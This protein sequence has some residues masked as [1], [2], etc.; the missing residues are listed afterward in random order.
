M[1]ISDLIFLPSSVWVLPVHYSHLVVIRYVSCS[2]V[3]QDDYCS[4]SKLF[5]SHIIH[6]HIFIHWTSYIIHLHTDYCCDYIALQCD[7][8]LYFFTISLFLLLTCS[9]SKHFGAGQS[10]SDRQTHTIIEKWRR[11]E[12]I[13]RKVG[14]RKTRTVVKNL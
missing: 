4:I 9:A 12:S 14:V 11:K 7:I 1:K 10:S 2:G 3:L 8:T 13:V 6:A 5:L